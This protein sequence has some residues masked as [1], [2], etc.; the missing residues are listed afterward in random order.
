MQKAAMPSERNWV[1]AGT[2]HS[3]FLNTF[4]I[5]CSSECPVFAKTGTVSQQ[6]KVFAGTTLFTAIVIYDDLSKLVGS[7][8]RKQPNIA[9]G[10]IS[11]AK[12]KGGEHYASKLGMQLIRELNQSE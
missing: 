11:K 6:D 12:H 5:A 1:G 7:E 9:I 2:A 8:L 3:A 10:V 4:G